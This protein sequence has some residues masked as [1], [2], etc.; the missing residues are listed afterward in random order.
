MDILKVENLCKSYKKKVLDD[1]S[2]AI[3]P[4][5]I[6]G[7]VGPN[8]V[9]KTT[10]MKIICLLANADSGNVSICDL[11]SKGNREQYLSKLSCTIETPA[12][13]E[14]LTG[15]DNI[16][17]IRDLNKVSKERM[18]EILDFVGVGK[19]IKE[20]VKNYSLGMKQRI[21]LGIALLTSPNLL[22]LDEPTNGLDPDGSAE[23]RKQ[24]LQ[25]VD[26]KDMAILIS[27]HILSELDKTCT[28]ILFLKEGRIIES[29]VEEVRTNNKKIT[30]TCENPDQ[31]E[32]SLGQFKNIRSIIKL[33]DHRICIKLSNESLKDVLT[34][35]I[36]EKE[37]FNDIEI[38]S[39]D[40]NDVY[41]SIYGGV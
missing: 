2:F 35:L 11:S 36:S 29:N 32:E 14:N 41:T 8:G 3:K 28:K 7:L 39:D 22:I 17:F 9:G 6:I 40:I 25:L 38:S 4:G 13:Y 31:V 12:L 16:E 23:F 10:L 27:S 37:M 33:N 20:K 26:K 1:V 19:M 21:G 34:K 18:K 5:E 30:L 15:Y 24:L